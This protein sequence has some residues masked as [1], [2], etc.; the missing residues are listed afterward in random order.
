MKHVRGIMLRNHIM[1]GAAAQADRQ[2][3][4]F[5]DIDAPAVPAEPG[6]EEEDPV[7]PGINTKWWRGWRCS[8]T[9]KELD[10]VKNRQYLR[11]LATKL[12]PTIQRMKQKE[13]LRR[14]PLPKRMAT[15]EQH[16]EAKR[17]RNKETSQYLRAMRNSSE[18]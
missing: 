14:E 1:T 4:P 8:Y 7:E 9:M 5:T 15:I 3:T 17:Q 11:S 10:P 18:P 16:A 12:G 6:I 13:A 2:G